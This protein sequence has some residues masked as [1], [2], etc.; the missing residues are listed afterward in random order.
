MNDLGEG[1][2]R[3]CVIEGGMMGT[4]CSDGNPGG[5]NLPSQPDPIRAI[6]GVWSGSFE[7]HS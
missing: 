4:G 2:K 1:M 6:R 7:R 5:A 3:D